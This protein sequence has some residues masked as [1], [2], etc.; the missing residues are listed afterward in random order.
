MTS[1]YEI[2]YAPSVWRLLNGVFCIYKPNHKSVSSTRR[3]L[4][5]NLCNDLNDMIV[6]PPRQMVQIAGDLSSGNELKVEIKENLSDNPLVVGKRYQQQDFALSVVNNP[7]YFASGVVVVFIGKMAKNANEFRRANHLRVYE[8][9]GR[10]GMTTDNAN[11]DGRIVEKSWFR[12]VNEGRISRVLSKIE[13]THQTLMYKVMG[14]DMTTQEAYDLASRGMVRP[15]MRKTIPILY[16]LRLTDLSLPEFTIEVE[17]SN[18][19]D[20]SLSTTLYC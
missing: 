6:R 5:N 4:L 10:L 1:L 17:Y 9:K 11:S 20:H 2:R 13:S 14:I 18:G 19:T 16:R 3:T 7:G 15:A 8:I 12:H